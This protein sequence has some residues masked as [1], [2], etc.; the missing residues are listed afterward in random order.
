MEQ[1]WPH[2]Q[3]SVLGEWVSWRWCNAKLMKKHKLAIPCGVVLLWVASGR[4]VLPG[5]V[6][7]GGEVACTPRVKAAA[8]W[9]ASDLGRIILGG[10]CYTLEAIDCRSKLRAGSQKSNPA[11]M[12]VGMGRVEP[13]GLGAASQS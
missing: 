8:D 4:S 7:D 10:L 1:N 12:A 3:W 6:D 5:P 11:R 13:G 9:L 2:A